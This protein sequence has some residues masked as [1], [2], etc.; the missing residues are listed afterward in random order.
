MFFLSVNT[1]SQKNDTIRENILITK[2]EILPISLITAGS[3]LNFGNMKYD[4]QSYVK[5]TNIK[6]DDYIQYAPI[7]IMY[8]SDAIGVKH[9]NTAFNQTKYLV[10]SEISAALTIFLLKKSTNVERPNKHQHSFPSWHTT[11]AFV[12]ATS[13]YYEFKDYNKLTA[14]SGFVFSTATG[15]LRITNNKHWISDV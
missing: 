6:A 7:G 2:K 14:Y 5:K 12:G 10:I 8:I 4:F 1:Y 3:L 13:L 15:I 11:Q 9:K